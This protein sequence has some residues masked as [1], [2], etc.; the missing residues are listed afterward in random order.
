MDNKEGKRLVMLDKC[1]F[2]R[3]RVVKKRTT[4]D[5]RWGE[6]LVVIEDVPVGVC[7]QCGEKYVDSDVYKKMESIAKGKRHVMGSMTVDVLN[8]QATT[9]G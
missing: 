5:Y 9:A 4:I 8:F 2:C 3:G 1:Y 7:Q 6:K